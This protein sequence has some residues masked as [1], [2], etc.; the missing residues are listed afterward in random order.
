MIKYRPIKNQFLIAMAKKGLNQKMLSSAAGLN[1]S[2]ISTF[3]NNKTAI[4][5]RSAQK[6]AEALSSEIE[7]IFEIELKNCMK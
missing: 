6:I 3:L 5:P 2:T 4:S 7:E 1:P